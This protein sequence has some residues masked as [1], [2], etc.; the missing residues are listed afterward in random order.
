MTTMAT[1]ADENLPRPV[2]VWTKLGQG[3]AILLKVITLRYVF[4]HENWKESPATRVRILLSFACLWAYLWI[5]V[6]L[7][8]YN[9]WRFVFIFPYFCALVVIAVFAVLYLMYGRT[10]SAL[11]LAFTITALVVFWFLL[12]NL[13]IFL[14]DGPI[15]PIH[16][17][18]WGV[19]W[20]IVIMATTLFLP[21][22]MIAIRPNEI[23]YYEDRQVQPD[24]YHLVSRPRPLIDPNTYRALLACPR[25]PNDELD[26]FIDF[27]G[28][29]YMRQT[30]LQKIDNADY[31]SRR[32]LHQLFH[33]IDHPTHPVDTV[34]W[35][36]AMDKVWLM[37]DTSET[38]WCS[39]NIR[40]LITRD[41]HPVDMH[42]QFGFAFD[43]NAI[44]RPE[45]RLKLRDVRSRD[46]L[47][48]QLLAKMEGTAK[49]IAQL[50][51]IDLSL[52]DALTSGSV[53][54]FGS[55]FV[56]KMT[57]TS[58]DGITIQS[59]TVQCVPILHQDVLEAEIQMQA[60][61]A[62][63]LEETARVQAL[64]DKIINQGVP[65][66]LLAGLLYLDRGGRNDYAALP[67]YTA[68]RGTIALPDP[69][70][71][72]LVHYPYGR[73]SAD[74]ADDDMSQQGGYGPTIG[75]N[76]PPER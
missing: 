69:A 16:M 6:T 30:L 71:G 34:L 66:E 26:R 21:I 31:V 76:R 60:S 64:I 46:D 40:Q 3:I 20:I 15:Q 44:Q 62:R 2:T 42:L 72:Q 54:N 1:S 50:Y 74:D 52:R 5:P 37:W 35:V 63:A 39:I 28:P 25:I 38:V 73:Q 65:P 14:F 32:M 67:P 17:I 56:Q 4:D 68:K 75:Q 49:G 29:V 12:V 7:V 36:S 55:T 19:I 51:F 24:G 58:M 9:F 45:A 22:W 47:K 10:R 57:W 61:R 48:A 70:T 18:V 8:L 59:G 13:P 41:G 53:K 11:N 27:N 33:Q 43:P 23:Y